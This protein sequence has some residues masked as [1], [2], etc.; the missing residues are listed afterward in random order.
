MLPRRPGL[1]VAFI[2]YHRS[3]VVIKAVVLTAMSLMVFRT[4]TILSVF[5][6][7]KSS[8]PYSSRHQIVGSIFCV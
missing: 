8:T 2:I 1:T 3:N 6:K 5:S 4:V 7:S